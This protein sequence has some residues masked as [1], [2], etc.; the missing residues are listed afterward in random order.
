MLPSFQKSKL[1]CIISKKKA[2]REGGVQVQVCL[3]IIPCALILPNAL[4]QTGVRKSPPN[5]L[6]GTVCCTSDLRA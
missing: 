3:G 6:R 4:E 2:E 5:M 1:L